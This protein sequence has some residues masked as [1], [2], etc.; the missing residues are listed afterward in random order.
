MKEVDDSTAQVCSQVV[1]H[2]SIQASRKV[3]LQVYMRVSEHANSQ[4]RREVIDQVQEN[5]II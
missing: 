1:K 5:L 4:V 3:Y 2:V